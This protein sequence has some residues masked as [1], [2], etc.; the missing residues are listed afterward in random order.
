MVLIKLTKH[1]L[2][3]IITIQSHTSIQYVAHTMCG[4]RSKINNYNCR[5][6]DPVGATC[7]RHAS[8]VQHG[9]RHH[10]RKALLRQMAL[11][12][13]VRVCKLDGFCEY[14]FNQ[15]QAVAKMHMR[16]AI[17]CNI[18]KICWCMSAHGGV[19]DKSL[20]EVS[21]ITERS[22]LESDLKLYFV[23]AFCLRCFCKTHHPCLVFFPFRVKNIYP[24]R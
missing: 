16:A 6:P 15:W 17:R 22:E 4:M 7:R 20:L 10:N 13:V 3:R 23:Q 8:I 21:I 14:C 12:S 19:R 5:W 11:R 1:E 24:I 2:I 18:Y 9:S